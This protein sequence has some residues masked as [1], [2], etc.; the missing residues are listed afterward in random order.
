MTV[1][2]IRDPAFTFRLDALRIH[3]KPAEQRQKFLGL[4]D[5]R[6]VQEGIV[7]GMSRP[8]AYGRADAYVA[9]VRE[10]IEFLDAAKGH[11][12][13]SVH[14]LPSKHIYR[15]KKRTTA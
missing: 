1:I 4:L 3:S 12:G 13:A 6:I 5:S 2:K 10:R 7:G 9:A 15:N 14:Y 11:Q 8:E